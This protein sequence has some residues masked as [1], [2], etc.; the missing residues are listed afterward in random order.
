M[1]N[2]VACGA[3]T[4]IAYI[5]DAEIGKGAI[6]GVAGLILG[7]NGIV[8]YQFTYL[9]PWW[10]AMDRRGRRSAAIGIKL[11]AALTA[12]HVGI[13]WASNPVVR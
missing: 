6:R 10:R 2:A 11:T 7:L 4:S 8:L 9:W 3:V 1:A 12:L 5:I 13:C